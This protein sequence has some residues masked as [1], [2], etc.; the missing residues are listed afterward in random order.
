[1]IQNIFKIALDICAGCVIFLF[2]INFEISFNDLTKKKIENN[3]S[4]NVFIVLT[5]T[6]NF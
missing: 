2:I 6:T 5:K 4:V 1:M 3:F